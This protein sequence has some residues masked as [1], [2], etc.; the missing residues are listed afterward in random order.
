VNLAETVAVAFRERFIE[1]PLSAA[2]AKRARLAQGDHCHST[3]S[4]AVIDC[5]W[6]SSLRDLPTNL[7]AIAVIFCQNDSIAP[8]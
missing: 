7:A 1:S 4:L 2:V 6:L 3:L 8:V 5:H